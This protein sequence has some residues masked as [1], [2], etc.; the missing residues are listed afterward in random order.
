MV[1]SVRFIK[2]IAV[3]LLAVLLVSVFS[4]CAGSRSGYTRIKGKP[5]KVG[6]VI[7][8]DASYYGKGFNGKKTASGEIFDED[9]YTC[10]HR[11]YPFGTMLEVVRDDTGAKVT[12]R[13]NDRGPHAKNRILDLSTA[14]AKELDMMKAGHVKVTATVVD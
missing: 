6:T 8:G 11:T 3:L 12:C 1:E 7:N 13:V 10:A 14:A 2:K 9:E 4:G 5:I